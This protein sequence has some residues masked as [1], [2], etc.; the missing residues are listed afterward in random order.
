MADSSAPL[1]GPDLAH[2]VAMAELQVGVP[3]SGHI[4]GVA[5]LLL[6]KGDTVAAV[7]ASCPHWHLPLVGG[8]VV[9]GTLR[10]PF[11]HACFDVETG[12]VLSGPALDRLP[13]FQ[14]S[15]EGDWIRV[16]L[17]KVHPPPLPA[18]S[19]PSAVVII[20]AGAAGAVC[21]ETLRLEGYEGDIT[22]VGD[23]G[24]VD[25]PNLSKAYL[26]G[27]AEPGWLPLRPDG[28]YDEHRIRVVLSDAA[29]GIDAANH[30]VRLTSNKMLDYGVLV[31]ATGAEPRPLSIPGGDLPHVL[32]LRTLADTDAILLRAKSA[33]HI[34][35]CGAG[36]IGL[37]VAASL[38]MRGLAVTV[39]APESIPLAVVLGD[40]LGRYLHNLHE[41]KGV[42]F[43]LGTQPTAVRL[44]SLELAD[45]SAL[46]AD[47]VVFGIG[48]VPRVALAE[49]AGLTVDNG[50]VVDEWLC[51]SNAN[52][53]AAGDVARFPFR[54][55]PVRI[56]HWLVA[57][58][59]ARAIARTL[60]GRGTPYEDIPFFWSQQ[61]DVSVS[62]V[63]H[64]PIWDEA[65]VYG[66][67][68]AGTAHVVYRGG[69]R[70]L[71]VATVGR[72]HLGLQVEAAMQ[73]N[74][75]REVE[76]LVSL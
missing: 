56:E 14:V 7:G 75:E 5:V 45:G 31:L 49:A 57:M 34:V 1:D 64:A 76:Q 6:R 17:P 65:R 25:R 72:D 42:G 18:T 68:A 67:L 22:I 71:A 8:L 24:P 37:E 39:V 23:E 44:D 59:H 69:G 41:S 48:V 73:Q 15:I 3:F 33:K 47:L 60:V 2:G 55:A 63:G 52:I 35:I 20:G 10:C 58:G 9:A 26:A 21:A 61:Y 19:G 36:F 40:D 70:I 43:R 16:G 38:R 46:D 27:E 74:D 30:Q 54:G 66:D 28:F 53:Y 11:H 13:T 62:L 12:L 50:I 4:G 32:A 29:V 51:T